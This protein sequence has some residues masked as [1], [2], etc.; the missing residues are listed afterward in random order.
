MKEFERY[1]RV[2]TMPHRSYYIPFAPG[3]TAGTVHG[4][5]DR[6]TSSRFLSLDGNW[7]IK[8][9]DHVEDFDV[10]EELTDTIPVPS[11]EDLSKRIE[12]RSIKEHPSR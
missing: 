7:Q 12:P 9:H 2:G 6:S 8:Q 3:D 4:I 10:S 5:I 1:E 11:C